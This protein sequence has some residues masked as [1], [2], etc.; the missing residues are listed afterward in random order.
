[1]Q[2]LNEAYEVLSDSNKRSNY[3]NFGHQDANGFG[4]VVFLEKVVL[5]VLE[6]YSKISLVGLVVSVLL[7]HTRKMHQEEVMI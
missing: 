7:I 1:M 4:N 2:E 3:D 6:I 5:V